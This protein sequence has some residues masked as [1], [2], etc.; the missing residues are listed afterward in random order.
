MFFNTIVYRILTYKTI[1]QNLCE[2]LRHG[3]WQSMNLIE[4]FT[5]TYLGSCFLE[6]KKEKKKPT[7]ICTIYTKEVYTMLGAFTLG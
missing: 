7:D 1:D 2:T 4:G 5:G 6:K 3:E